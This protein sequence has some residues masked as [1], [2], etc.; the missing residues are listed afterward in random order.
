MKKKQIL[1]PLVSAMLFGCYG[2]D[3]STET[4]QS[5]LNNL[6]GQ[7]NSFAGDGKKVEGIDPYDQALYN[8]R[9]KGGLT[10]PKTTCSSDN[11]VCAVQSDNKLS[12]SFIVGYSGKH[13]WV[14][15]DVLGNLVLKFNKDMP[16]TY[17]VSE[18]YNDLGTST[19]KVGYLTEID[20]SNCDNLIATGKTKGKEC[21]IKFAYSGEAFNS[22]SQ[23]IHFEL[24]DGTDSKTNN[25]DVVYV[26]KN[27]SATVQNVP[28]LNITTANTLFKDDSLSDVV[29]INY[30][31]EAKQ[32]GIN[33]PADKLDAFSVSNV[34]T[35]PLNK[36]DDTLFNM[37]VSSNYASSEGVYYSQL[38][39]CQHDI[40]LKHG[41]TCTMPLSFRTGLVSQ[42]TIQG[43]TNRLVL[44]YNQDHDA[45][46]ITYAKRVI[47]SPGL[48]Q[49]INVSSN[50][51]IAQGAGPAEWYEDLSI[52]ISN[53]G[54][55]IL[56]YGVPINNFK[57]SLEY[58]PKFYLTHSV[59][60]INGDKEYRLLYSYGNIGKYSS[61][62]E[63]LSSLKITPDTE[64]FATPDTESPTSGMVSDGMLLSHHCNVTISA[65]N[66]EELIGLKKP[67]AAMLVATYNAPLYDKPVKQ[68]LGTLGV[69]FSDAEVR[70]GSGKR[71]LY[72]I[73]KSLSGIRGLE[74]DKINLYPVQKKSLMKPFVFNELDSIRGGTMVQHDIT[75]QL[76]AWINSNREQVCTMDFPVT[77]R[78]T[79]SL[80][81]DY[82]NELARPL[83]F[84]L[85]FMIP[86]GQ[87]WATYPLKSDSI[88]RIEDASMDG[89]YWSKYGQSL[90]EDKI[91]Y[92]LNQDYVL[93]PDDLSKA[94]GVHK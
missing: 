85:V 43:G 77:L 12:S 79:F 56:S 28:A 66:P 83:P 84:S 78:C 76:F 44:N 90:V 37:R 32:S 63:L 30:P 27:I 92:I 42:D 61:Q 82:A 26:A 73:T 54:S 10:E 91:S 38:T 13:V 62:E 11:G 51:I 2:H 59:V 94:R 34:G 49:P 93:Y 72:R 24:S 19:S 6:Q 65:N 48:L 74:E 55:G 20:T 22:M 46:P 23:N 41:N 7:F 17:H 50:G 47:F 58:D 68:V 15:R 88:A 25:L 35:E 3:G 21:K 86:Y 36:Y 8:P 31:L 16:K 52:G 29:M 89:R 39:S 1:L 87:N 18:L 4:N 14:V 67:I 60:Q 71:V 5:S 81:D 57:L 33:F 40:T 69:N 9:V 75:D 70:K 80:G 45:N 64:C 53:L